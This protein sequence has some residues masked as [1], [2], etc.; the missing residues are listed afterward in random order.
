M[1]YKNAFTI[2]FSAALRDPH[3]DIFF[4]ATKAFSKIIHFVL[5]RSSRLLKSYSLTTQ[6]VTAL[7]VFK[8]L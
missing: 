6:S 8:I 3:A 2:L 7:R 1:F 4:Y 5:L